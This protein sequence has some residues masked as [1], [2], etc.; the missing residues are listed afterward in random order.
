MGKRVRLDHYTQHD[1]N[2]ESEGFLI[3]TWIL[4]GTGAVLGFSVC[5]WTGAFIGLCIGCGFT[6]W[7]WE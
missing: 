5:G 1:R 7:L 2:N 6:S 3:L 4:G